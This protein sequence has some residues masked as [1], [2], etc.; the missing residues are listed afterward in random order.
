MQD[1]H[2]AIDDDS[3]QVRSAAI[4]WAKTGDPSLVGELVRVVERLTASVEDHFG[5]EERDVIPLIAQYLSPKEWRKFLAHGSAFVRAH[6]RR[7]LAL[8]GMVLD[9]ASAEIRNR[10][11]GNVPLPARIPF[12]LFG[13]RVYAGYRAQIYGSE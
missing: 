12:K 11:L 10:F 7:G 8:G 6:P 1:A 2:R 5:D 4:R 3:A 13:D 9:G